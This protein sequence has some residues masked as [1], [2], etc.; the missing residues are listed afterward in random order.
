M[1]QRIVYATNI[2]DSSPVS[3][4]QVIGHRK[5]MEVIT[6]NNGTAYFF[7]YSADANRYPVYMT[8]VLKMLESLE[9][10]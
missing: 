5:T 3:G 10:K 1:A 4:A 6:V 9:I 8:N 2:I 7:V